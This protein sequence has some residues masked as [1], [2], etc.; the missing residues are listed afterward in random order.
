[1]KPHYRYIFFSVDDIVKAVFQK[2][3]ETV[4]GEQYASKLEKCINRMN[5][6][7][8]EYVFEKLFINYL[9]YAQSLYWETHGLKVIWSSHEELPGNLDELQKAP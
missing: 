9:I 5:E 1:M 3:L 8:S 4:P 7:D 2:E 6:E